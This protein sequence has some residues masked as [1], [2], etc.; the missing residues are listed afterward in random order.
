MNSKKRKNR[1]KVISKTK[2]RTEV[3]TKID[4]VT[5]DKLS[6]SSLNL[7][8]ITQ[9]KIDVTEAIVEETKVENDEINDE[10]TEPTKEI[11]STTDTPVKPKRN[12]GKK[13][14]PTIIENQQQYTKNEEIEK[15][16]TNE[17]NCNLPNV[18]D[19][20]IIDG[21][22]VKPS[23]RK[24][25]NKETKHTEKSHDIEIDNKSDII[26]TIPANEIPSQKNPD[27]E[28]EVETKRSKKNKK[29]KRRH[30]SE[31]SDKPDEVVSCTAAFED[32]IE[33][34][35]ETENIEN[36]EKKD[37]ETYK[38]EPIECVVDPDVMLSIENQNTNNTETLQIDGKVTHKKKKKGKKQPPEL[39]DDNKKESNQQSSIQIYKHIQTDVLNVA[40][41]QQISEDTRTDNKDDSVATSILKSDTEEIKPKARIAKP[42]Q[43][44]TVHSSDLKNVIETKTAEMLEPSITES[45]LS[46]TDKEINDSLTPTNESN[47]LT[48]IESDIVGQC[49]NVTNLEEN[50]S[51][52]EL[53][54]CA[55]EQSVTEKKLNDKC[56]KCTIESDKLEIK[57]ESNVG[58]NIKIQDTNENNKQDEEP[59]LEEMPRK[60]K[61]KAKRQVKCSE[62]DD[63]DTATS[64]ESHYNISNNVIGPQSVSQ[65][66]LD[67]NIQ[68]VTS[69][70]SKSSNIPVPSTIMQ[71]TPTRTSTKTPDVCET[72]TTQQEKTDLK[73]KMME[74][75]KDLEQIRMSLEKSLAE[76]SSLKETEEKMARN[77]CDV[78]TSK[79]NKPEKSTKGIINAPIPSKNI[80]SAQLKTEND[81]YIDN[82]DST[83]PPI[84]PRRKDQKC[85]AK[86]KRREQE[87][88]PQTMS[89]TSE[90]RNTS[91]N[92]S[93]R[94]EKGNSSDERGQQQ[95][96]CDKERNKTMSSDVQFEPIENFEDALTSSVD[97]VEV[98]K[99]FE[100]IANELNE[101]ILNNPQKESFITKP[102]INITPPL[103][104]EENKGQSKNIN[105][106][107]QPKNLLGCPN[108]PV[109]SN[110]TDYKKEKNKT[111]NEQQA[112]VK[113]KDLIDA[114][115][116]DESVKKS[117]QSQTDSKIKF[118]KDKNEIE[119]FSYI[120]N[121]NEEYVYKYIFRKVFLSSVCHI[122]RKDLKQ[123]RVPCKFC[124]ILFYCSQKHKD[125]D[126]PRH[127]SLCFAVSTIV[128]LKDQKHI[129]SDT[130]N[131][132]GQNYRLIRMHMILSCEKVLKRK[133]LPWE[134]EA[135][136]YP[137]MC[138]DVT[139]REWR[140]TKLMDCDGCGQVSY[141]IENPDHLPPVHQRWCKP[142]ALYQKLVLY[143]QEHGRLEPRL[144]GKVMTHH[145]NIPDKMNEVLAAMYEEKIDM[146][147]V[148]YAAL[149]QLASTPLTVAFCHQLH[150]HAI[151][152]N[153]VNT[154][155]GHNKRST[156]TIHVVGAELQLEADSLGKW[157]VFLLHLKPGLKELRV[158]LVG[159]DLNAANLP[160]DLLGKIRLCENCRVNKRRVTFSFHDKKSYHEYWASDDFTIPDIVCAFNPNIHRSSLYN[161]VEVWSSTI[162]C[163]FKQKI[164]FL[165]TSSTMR[166]LKDD[167]ET[168]K[169]NTEVD[170]KVIS[171]VKLN[172]FASVRPDRNFITDDETPLLFK[173]YCFSLLCGA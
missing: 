104:E 78:E 122:C 57:L 134:Q 18:S 161:G 146:S 172:P 88:V 81:S 166:E 2:P 92:E 96:S 102:E 6:E 1:A 22:A 76:L 9:D 46:H 150:R 69:R 27:E 24:K 100:V 85:R 153:A 75:N 135:L 98:N 40:D 108:I 125:E 7:T 71:E 74:V 144:P 83:T 163:I 127:Q 84:S 16:L 44:K 67:D 156:F 97:D 66:L 90:S 12:K 54:D 116:D 62:T 143:Q 154:V 31:K 30:D 139:C 126:W 47:I 14:K 10:T 169:N 80:K 73:S 91:T 111:P 23:A 112:K 136:L 26:P 93:R 162:N 160:L 11:T 138:I 50:T 170:Y 113:I 148:Q 155:N 151:T 110:K 128:H 4:D 68:E 159:H 119:S 131:V 117:K 152:G 8:D 121:G 39:K 158:A 21:V 38:E 165:I 142:Y 82:S 115:L 13:K 120:K 114:E 20:T 167:L 149:T 36:V 106:V 103:D 19:A 34:K 94:K 107:S 59:K 3:E 56:Q 72:N 140:Q 157:E 41:S 109:P 15:N 105:P 65:Q 171:D 137:R 32:L 42:V 87:T 55:I 70:H 51:N 53:L 95:S 29:K 58:F 132:S 164:P 101:D 133:L 118:I 60:G 89:V 99:T 48:P 123:T 129:Y 173:N 35:T 63:Y 43:K 64:D 130:Q 28:P 145:Y 61:S 168:I 49:E 17:E 79:N 5:V 33:K 147:D 37:Q 45:N 77:E 52:I 124:N 141:C 86:K 25:K